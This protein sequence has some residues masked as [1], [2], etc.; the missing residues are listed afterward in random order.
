MSHLQRGG[1]WNLAGAKLGLS[2]L[3]SESYVTEQIKLEKHFARAER[4]EGLDQCR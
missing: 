4:D 2:G 3:Q 1:H